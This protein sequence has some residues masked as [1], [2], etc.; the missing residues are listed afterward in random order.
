MT[1]EVFIGSEL[2]TGLEISCVITAKR[3][4]KK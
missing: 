3:E 1:A 4:E 2:E